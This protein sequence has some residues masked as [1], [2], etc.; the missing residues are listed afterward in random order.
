[1]Y[2]S[3][4]VSNIKESKFFESL[5]TKQSIKIHHEEKIKE[6]VIQQITIREASGW[7]VMFSIKEGVYWTLFKGEYVPKEETIKGKQ[8]AKHIPESN[9]LELEY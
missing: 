7:N 8:L 5:K 3:I 9:I 2:P 4:T 6:M 1:M